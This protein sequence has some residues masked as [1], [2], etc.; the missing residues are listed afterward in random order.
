MIPIKNLLL[1]FKNLTNTEKNK[2]EIII[3]ICKK[4]NIPLT[5]KQIFFSKD[6]IVIKTAPII[7]T[8]ILLKKNDLLKKIN[9]EI[10]NG[11]YRDIQ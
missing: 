9:Q 4:N 2:K 1:R 6:R 5:S 8:E 7:K 10:I 11:F 3:D